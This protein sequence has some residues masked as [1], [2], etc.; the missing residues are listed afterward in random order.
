MLARSEAFLMSRGTIR[1][2]RLGGGNRMVRES[3]E[4]PRWLQRREDRTAGRYG[5]NKVVRWI[6]R[7]NLK[8]RSAA[9]TEA[10]AAQEWPRITGFGMLRLVS[11]N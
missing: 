7:R 9:T 6:A 4:R 3:E 1:G 8:E 2:G 11:D 10:P 5:G